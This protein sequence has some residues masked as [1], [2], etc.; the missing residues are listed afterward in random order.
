MTAKPRI[1]LA[2][3]AAAAGVSKMTASRALRG[4]SDVSQSSVHAVRR[5]AEALGYIGNPVAGS[6]SSQRSNLIGVVVPS[7]T[8]IVFAEVLSG[9]AGAL[10]GSGKQPV[11]GVSDYDPETE[12]TVIRNMLSWRPRGLIVTGLDQPEK[13]LRLLR[14]ADIPIVQIMDL[15]GAPV[16]ACVGVGHAE[17]GRMMARAL[18]QEGRQ[19]IGYIGCGL[20]RDTRAAKRL[21]GFTEALSA[22]GQA[23]YTQTLAGGLSTMTAGRRLTAQLLEQSPELDAIYYSNDDLATGGVFQCIAKGISVPDTL[24]LAG[25]NGLDF[26]DSLPAPLATARTPR[27]EIGVTA[28]RIILEVESGANPP[29]R[30]AY[31]PETVLP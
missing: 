9:I 25:F 15:D 13:T 8:N 27:R 30:V 31:T 7:L 24:R 10:T 6:L 21:S 4:A 28:A 2:D 17:A 26:V 29:R 19:R 22:A 3:V 14:E 16:D 1:T 5:A 20:D 11:F 18:L 23:L 12:Y